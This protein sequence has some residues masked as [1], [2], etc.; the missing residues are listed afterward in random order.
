M[1]T[2]EE[3]KAHSSEASSVVELKEI[4]PGV[5]EPASNECD[6]EPVPL[7]TRKRL[8]RRSEFDRV[9]DE[10]VTGFKTGMSLVR[11]IGK[12]LNVRL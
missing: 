7:R 9:E 5:Y 11:R 10:V 8:R 2:N 1:S 12:A 4:K 3:G 6:A